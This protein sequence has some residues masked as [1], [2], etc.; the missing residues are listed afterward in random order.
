M[1]LVKQ[2]LGNISSAAEGADTVPTFQ[3]EFDTHLCT[4]FTTVVTSQLS[5]GQ[6]WY[7]LLDLSP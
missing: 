4:L 7:V 6:S 3:G 2:V 5:R 1:Q